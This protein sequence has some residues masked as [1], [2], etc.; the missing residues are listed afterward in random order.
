VRTAEI[1]DSLERQ[2]HNPFVKQNQVS[3][4]QR[5]ILFGHDRV[6]LSHNYRCAATI[7]DFPNQEFY[8]GQVIT[9]DRKPFSKE[10]SVINHFNKKYRFQRD[11]VNVKTQ[12]FFVDCNARHDTVET[13]R[14]LTNQDFVDVGMEI[15]HGFFQN[16]FWNA[17][18]CIITSYKAQHGLWQKAI[19]SFSHPR[20]QEFIVDE[21][22]RRE[23]WDYLKVMNSV[24]GKSI[25][26]IGKELGRVLPPLH[27]EVRTT[28]TVQGHQEDVVIFDLTRTRGVGF[29]RNPQKLNV[30]LTRAKFGMIVI[31]NINMFEGLERVHS[32]ARTKHLANLLDDFNAKGTIHKMKAPSTRKGPSSCRKCGEIGHTAAL[33][34]RKYQAQYIVCHNCKNT[35]HKAS[36][37][38]VGKII[39]CTNCLGTGHDASICLNPASVSD[40]KCRNCD[41]TGHV[42]AQCPEIICSRCEGVGHEIKQCKTVLGTVFYHMRAMSKMSPEEKVPF[43][44]QYKRK[45]DLANEKTTNTTLGD[46]ASASADMPTSTTLHE[47]SMSPRKR[48]RS[49]VFG[50]GSLRHASADL[51][52]N[53]E[54][55]RASSGSNTDGLN[56][57]SGNVWSENVDYT[58]SDLRASAW[59]LHAYADSP[60]TKIDTCNE[61]ETMEGMQ[62]DREKPKDMEDSTEGQEGKS[63]DKV[64]W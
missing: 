52:N 26:Q 63:E 43:L 31:G 59:N 9:P 4:F 37:C 30:A 22:H 54:P 39:R 21:K 12:S 1:T 36:E 5:A 27:I 62:S 6:F 61:E 41:S 17:N 60:E 28:G 42:K 24:G 64:Q 55:E 58:H 44:E 7:A 2:V 10:T 49:E 15:I 23:S 29:L 51:D 38:P 18:V 19:D 20:L 50:T 25:D 56:Q 32:N 35:G 34:P 47:S 11:N 8:H 3:F 13:T 16:P 45:Q 48:S 46:S 53:A 33:C 40:R 14:S 57:G